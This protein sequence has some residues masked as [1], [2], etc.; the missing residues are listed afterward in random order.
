M[1]N[2]KLS[3]FLFFSFLICKI[4]MGPTSGLLWRLNGI[5]YIECLNDVV[6][7][8]GLGFVQVLPW[9]VGARPWTFIKWRNRLSVTKS[10]NSEILIQWLFSGFK[11]L[12]LLYSQH[13]V[14][15]GCFLHIT[16]KLWMKGFYEMNYWRESSLGILVDDQILCIHA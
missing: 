9:I 12:F 8:T 3:N 14:W 11:W 7:I 13:R 5:I 15:E 2:D 10:Y 6:E 16:L 1:H 4:V